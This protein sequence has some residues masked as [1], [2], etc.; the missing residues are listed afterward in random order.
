M[1]APWRMCRAA[2]WLVR[3]ARSSKGLAEAP[4]SGVVVA[5]VLSVTRH[6]NADRLNVCEVDAGTGTPAPFSFYEIRAARERGIS[7]HALA[8]AAV[9]QV[10]LEVHGKDAPPA[11]VLCVRGESFELGDGLT[12]QGS[13]HLEA[14]WVWLRRCLDDARPEAWRKAAT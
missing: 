3:K 8:P 5:Q 4:F 9:L 14:A 7:S 12:P 6:P 11:F 13:G 10:F 1:P 2:G